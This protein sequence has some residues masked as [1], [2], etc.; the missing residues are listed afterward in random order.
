MHLNTETLSPA[1]Y[2]EE[3]VYSS[4]HAMLDG[5]VGAFRSLFHLCTTENSHVGVL[6]QWFETRQAAVERVGPRFA[7]ENDSI[8]LDSIAFVVFKG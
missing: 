8:D 4:G 3:G 6:A 1:P 5:G 2:W 7:R